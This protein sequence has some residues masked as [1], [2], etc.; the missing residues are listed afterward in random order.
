MQPT[1]Q[2]RARSFGARCLLVERKIRLYMIG[3]LACF[4]LAT[5]FANLYLSVSIAIGNSPEIGLPFA[6][7]LLFLAVFLAL[8][9][10]AIAFAVISTWLAIMEAMSSGNS[11]IWKLC[12]SLFMIFFFP[13]GL[14]LYFFLARTRLEL[15]IPRPKPE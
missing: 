3:A 8:A 4:I 11:D 6:V 5:F 15:R 13:L 2:S 14:V 10:A 7:C 12:W 1:L 9:T